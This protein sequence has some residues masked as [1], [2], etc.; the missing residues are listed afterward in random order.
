MLTTFHPIERKQ[1]SKHG[2]FVSNFFFHSRMVENT[3]SSS[4]NIKATITPSQNLA[5]YIAWLEPIP[6]TQPSGL[7]EAQ[8]LPHATLQRTVAPKWSSPQKKGYPSIRRHYKPCNA[9]HRCHHDVSCSPKCG[10]TP[11]FKWSQGF[12]SPN[13]RNPKAF[14]PTSLRLRTRGNPSQNM[15][16]HAHSG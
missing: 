14:S 5:P 9:Q 11:R 16:H 3:R 13:V 4:K 12:V 6:T 15:P 8:S 7:V 10:T 2:T 1:N